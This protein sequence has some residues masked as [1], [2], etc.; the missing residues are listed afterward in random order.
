[1]TPFFAIRMLGKQPKQRPRNMAG[2]IPPK[3]FF[4][5]EFHA[6]PSPPG[7]FSVIIIFKIKCLLLNFGKTSI[8][9]LG[10][11]TGLPV[12]VELPS[13]AQNVVFVTCKHSLMYQ[14]QR[15]MSM[16]ICCYSNSIP[17]ALKG[18]FSP[19]QNSLCSLTMFFSR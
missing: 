2:P 19:L 13:K 8:L 16:S 4:V 3:N 1:M 15:Q 11:L 6:G 7:E 9:Q 14:F 18:F 5:L 17:T 10:E 12:A